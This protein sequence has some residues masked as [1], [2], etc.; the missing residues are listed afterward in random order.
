[1]GRAKLRPG[2]LL[3]YNNG[4]HVALYIGK[5]YMIEASSSQGRVI[6][7]PL[8]GDWHSE[9]YEQGRRLIG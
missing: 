1:V 9:T 8:R 7:A 5:G 6:T 4:G 2:D 3:I